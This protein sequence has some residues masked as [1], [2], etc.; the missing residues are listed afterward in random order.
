MIRLLPPITTIQPGSF[1]KYGA[2]AFSIKSGSRG[3][4]LITSSVSR[5]TPVTISLHSIDGRT[6][7]EKSSIAFEAGNSACVLG[8]NLKGKGVYLVKIT[9]DGINL[10]KQVVMTK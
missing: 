2:E 4:V 5:K 6:L 3:T 8:N 10:S 1:L 7:M 9:G